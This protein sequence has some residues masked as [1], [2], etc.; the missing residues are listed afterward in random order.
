M[1]TVDF[2]LD[3][4]KIAILPDIR[5]IVDQSVDTRFRVFENRYEDDMAAIQQDF[6]AVYGR[7]DSIEKELGAVKQDVAELKQDVAGLKQDMSKVKKDLVEI[8]HEMKSQNRL[9]NRHS[10][11]IMRLRAVQEG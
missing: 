2:T 1:A 10:Q 4:L 5:Q 9:V 3:E 7:F 11:D 8:K 6:L